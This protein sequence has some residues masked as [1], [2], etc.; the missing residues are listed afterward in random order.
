MIFAQPGM[1]LQRQRRY[2]WGK[3]C[4]ERGHPE[5]YNVKYW[6]IGNEMGSDH[7]EGPDDAVSYPKAVL[8][9]I[10]AIKKADPSLWLCMSGDWSKKEWFTKSFVKL[11]PFVES[12]S[13]HNYFS[14]PFNLFGPKAKFEYEYEANS[15]PDRAVKDAWAARKLMEKYSPER[16]V[17]GDVL[18]RVEYLGLLAQRAIRRR[19]HICRETDKH[20]RAGS[21][22]AGDD[23]CVL[24]QPVNEGCIIVEPF[25]SRLTNIGL[26]FKHFKAARRE[27]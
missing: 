12:F 20:A 3:I 27:L 26:V 16:Q 8:P 18:R 2:K 19:R 1:I 17:V 15:E 11:A 10:K 7:M 23:G 22:R 5:P 24:F 4:A 14:T 13:V 25:G 21:P 9:I 6:S